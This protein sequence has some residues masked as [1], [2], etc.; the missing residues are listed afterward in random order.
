MQD[1]RVHG[2]MW[3]A[4]TRD[5][6]GVTDAKLRRFRYGVQ[7]N[8]LGLTAAAAGEQ[9]G[10]HRARDA[11]G[12]VER[13]GAGARGAAAG[14]ERGAGL[15]R[16]PWDQQW[17]LRAQQ[18]L[19]FESD[20]LE[21]PD[22][23]DGSKVVE[24]KVEELERGAWGEIAS[25]LGIEGHDGGPPHAEALPS[26][27][28]QLVAAISSGK[29]KERLV[30]VERRAA[31]AH[32]GGRAD[33]RRRE[34]VQG[35]RSLAADRGGQG[36]DPEREPGR[37]ARGHR[38]AGSVPE[39]TR[40]EARVK[41]AL[42]ELAAAAASGANVMPVSIVCAHAGV[43]TG[44]WAGTLRQVFG[45]WRAP[46]GVVAVVAGHER[47]ST[48]GSIAGDLLATLRADVLRLREELGRP[49]K[50]LVG[51]PG[52]DGHSNGAE[53]IALRA[54]DAG[55]EVVYDGIRV[56]PDELVTSAIEEGV[57]LVGLSILSGSHLE[58]VPAILDGLR[59]AGADIPVVVGGIIP[60]EDAAR[61]RALGVARI[62]T[63]KDFAVAGIL[64][65]LVDVVRAAQLPGSG[66]ASTAA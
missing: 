64:H 21:Y 36:V 9:R 7:V 16:A 29:I 31:G 37:G 11:G 65:D 44:E 1:A 2:Q 8:S 34:Q 59:A 28:A 42:A 38:A 41:N 49:P 54:R 13:E 30:V 24:A 48:D 50:M 5:R 52:L 45:E 47:S 27:T 46:T 18:I 35:D 23:F 56:S 12:D 14:V 10:A 6:Y 58:L 39:A 17:S 40:D 3:D 43:T 4:L 19:A 33:R 51:K 55:F 53:Q 32:R 20:L 25:I 57:H 26:V 66:S 63:P 15:C 62:F 61:L 60:D 22:L